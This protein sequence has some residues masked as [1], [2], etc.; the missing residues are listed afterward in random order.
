MASNSNVNNIRMI[1]ALTLVHFTGDFYS[2]FINPLFPLFVAKLDLSLTQVGIIAGVSRLLAFIVQPSVGYLSDRY[3]TRGF[4]LGGL[5]LVVVFTALSG[6]APS[7][8]ILL[9]CI[10]LGSLGSSMFHPS[11]P[12]SNR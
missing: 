6:I 1:F 4:I 10:A 12:S 9:P 8:W 3:Q 5:L 2:S 11:Y 7:F